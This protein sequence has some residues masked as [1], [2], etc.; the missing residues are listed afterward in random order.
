LEKNARSDQNG[1]PMP[2]MVICANRAIK[3]GEEILTD[4]GTGV[5]HTQENTCV[6]LSFLFQRCA[7][8]P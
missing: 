7:R 4:Y 6:I 2:V 3:K 8:L 5:S 1:Q